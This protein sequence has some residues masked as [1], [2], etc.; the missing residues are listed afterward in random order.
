ML[1]GNL[2]VPHVWGR[3]IIITNIVDE[4]DIIING[5]YIGR[6]VGAIRL[7]APDYLELGSNEIIAILECV[8][9][10]IEA[11][12]ILNGIGGAYLVTREDLSIDRV[13]YK[14]TGIMKVSTLKGRPEE[15]TEDYDDSKWNEAELP[16]EKSVEYRG[17]RALWIR[18]KAEIRHSK[19]RKGV[20]LEL[21]GE[22]DFWVYINDE[23]L[24]LNFLGRA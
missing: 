21:E 10:D 22:G 13:R 14:E 5:K 23:P 9:R 3:D 16:L 6:V 19:D 11:L 17:K 24:L 8:G 1:R 15:A 7:P 2:E 12:K 18:A 4:A 20:L